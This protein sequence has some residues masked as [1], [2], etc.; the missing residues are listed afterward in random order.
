MIVVAY[1][2]KAK[3]RIKSL[4][5]TL[6]THIT[7]LDEKLLF[8][9]HSYDPDEEN[10]NYDYDQKL[11]HLRKEIEYSVGLRRRLLALYKAAAE[12]DSMS[13]EELNDRINVIM[14]WEGVV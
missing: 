13:D 6:D 7:T 5:K 2:G 1:H 14:N 3:T 10:L 12:D 11:R 9:L 8:V 4:V